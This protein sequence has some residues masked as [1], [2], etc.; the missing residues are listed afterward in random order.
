MWAFIT[1]VA[2]LAIFAII[3]LIYKRCARC[4]RRLK[5]CSVDDSREAAIEVFL[6]CASAYLPLWG[7]SFF[8]SLTDLPSGSVGKY[9][10]SF[11][12]SG[13]V[14]LIACAI[15]GPLIYII[16]RKYGKFFGPLTV[17]FPYNIPFTIF[18]VVIWLFA[19]GVA[20]GTK[21]GELYEKKIFA[22]AALSILSV[23]MTLTAIAVLYFATVL[24]N[25]IE[26]LDPGQ[27]MHD[28]QERFVKEFGRG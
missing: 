2:C 17:Q 28:E 23:S 4:F 9:A 16:G 27:L 11:V 5:A 7:G 22:D 24:S 19:G 3:T 26:K 1:L 15:I 20:F 13:E 25:C 10:T 12:A 18:I 21:A 8:L 14:L 6:I